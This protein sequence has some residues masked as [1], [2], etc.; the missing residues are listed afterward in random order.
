M[1]Y[2]T[3]FSHTETF[4]QEIALKSKMTSSS[5]TMVI[6]SLLLNSLEKL[7]T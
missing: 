2:D 4:K 6:K 1:R 3:L 5:N 7:F